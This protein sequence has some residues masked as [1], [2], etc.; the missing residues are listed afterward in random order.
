MITL[1]H[2]V[3]RLIADF[4]TF[5]VFNKKNLPKKKKK[6]KKPK[7]YEDWKNLDNCTNNK[8]GMFFVML[9]HVRYIYYLIIIITIFINEHVYKNTKG[10]YH[11]NNSAF[12]L[13][14][15]IRKH[16]SAVF[17]YN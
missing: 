5:L 17:S 2:F 4:F 13:L 6:N 15:H 12:I 10:I 16:N 14:M 9:S 8:K 7:K 11:G 1:F 3:F